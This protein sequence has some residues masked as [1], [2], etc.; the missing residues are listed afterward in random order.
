MKRRLAAILA[1]DVVGYSAMIQRD[2]VGT[3][4]VVKGHFAA[5]EPHVA[6]HQ[7]RIVKKMG[8]GFLAEFSSVV[9]AVA[10][11]VELQKTAIARNQ[12][13][14]PARQAILRMGVHAGDIIE[15]EGDIFGDGVN[16][17]SRLEGIATPGS[18]AMSAKVHDEV[19]A[20]LDLVFEDRGSRTLKNIDRPLRVFEVTVGAASVPQR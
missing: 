15:E 2:E 14:E 7:G 13:L 9:E 5:F 4:Q 1:A 10:C 6:L 18:I 8:D 19:E 12:S 16:I 20:R 17:A 11:A 3:L